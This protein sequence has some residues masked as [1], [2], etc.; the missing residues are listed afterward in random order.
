MV[1]TRITPAC[2][3]SAEP[4]GAHRVPLRRRARAA[5]H[6]HR[7]DQ[8]RAAH[9]AGELAGVAQGLQVHQHDVG[10]RVVVP[11]L[12]QVVAGDVGAVARRDERG[13]AG[14]AGDAAAAPVQPG[15]QGD[16]DRAGLGE[17]ADA[18]GART[19]V[20]ERG[21]EPH[22]GVRVHDPEGVGADEAHPV[23]AGLPDQ[24][25]LPF[26]P[27]GAH[28]RV[29]GG[30]HHQALH[31]VLAALVDHARDLLGGHGDHRE[32][33]G[34]V[35]LAHRAVRGDAVDLLD[36]GLVE[37]A[38]HGVQAAGVARAADV[39]EDAAPH[40]AGRPAHTDHGDRARREQ[41]LHGTGLGALLAGPLHGQGAVG[42]LQVQLQAHHAVLEAALLGVAGVGEHL[43]HPGVRGQHLGGEPPDAAFARDRRDVL[44]QRGRHA[45]A[46]VRV[47]HQE[48]HLGL[49][50]GRGGRQPVGADAVV[51]DGAD[52]LP[53]DRRG[54]ADAVH[55]VVVREPVHVL[56]GQ[57]GVGG[58]EAVVLRL[59]GDLLVEA[60]QAVGVVDG[61]GAD[62][63][64]AAVAQHHV[65]FPVRGVLVPVRRGLHGAQTTA[66]GRARREA[67]RP[68]AKRRTGRAP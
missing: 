3:S 30:D 29:P 27:L 47:L 7:L 32:V 48:R 10:V 11:V 67:V 5:H 49:V 62:A 65:G 25:T 14:D 64:G 56:R 61:D 52:E 26:Q 55:V 42:G 19:A 54:Q 39:A 41:A 22:L 31:T 59:V 68:E 37:R 12:Q 57:P 33:H 38:V 66:R 20:G 35:D 60:D 45:A 15:Q 34:S 13:D 44:Q 24:G 58:E 6:D 40:A 43:D 28:L 46:L 9:Q 21:V 50:G 53:A 17:Q 2:R 51:A 16:A 36:A 18:A 23:R 63:R 1:S 8:G 4:C